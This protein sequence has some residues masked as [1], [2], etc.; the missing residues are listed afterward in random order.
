MSIF[1]CEMSGIPGAVCPIAKGVDGG[2]CP[3]VGVRMGQALNLF[4]STP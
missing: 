2:F 1:V 3:G 4:S